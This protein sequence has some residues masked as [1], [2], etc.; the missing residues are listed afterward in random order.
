MK[1]SPISIIVYTIAATIGL[2]LIESLI[3]PTYGYLLM[4]KMALFL[5]VPL[6]I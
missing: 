4:F 5:L 1:L 6:G 2:Y 3:H